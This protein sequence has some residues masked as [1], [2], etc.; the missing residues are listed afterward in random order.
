MN[1]CPFSTDSLQY[2][3]IVIE[4]Y[5]RWRIGGS[6]LGFSCF[7]NVVGMPQPVEHRRIV[8]LSEDDF[9]IVDRVYATLAVRDRELLEVEYTR[10]CHPKDKAAECGYGATD[11]V[12][13]A[14][15][16]YKRDVRQAESR[17]YSALLPHIDEWEQAKPVRRKRT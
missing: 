5:M 1:D 16:Q 14:I 17:M 9:T 2:L 7:A 13:A 4:A 10:E 11:N 12:P 3:R 6:N 15:A 8:D